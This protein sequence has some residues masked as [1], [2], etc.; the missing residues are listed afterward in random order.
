MALG[1]R[2][3]AVAGAVALAVFGGA[4]SSA[5]QSGRS[6]SSSTRS[7]MTVAEK[8]RV[9]P[10]PPGF[11][12]VVTEVDG[13]V[14]A[15]A[16]GRTFYRWPRNGQRNGEAG[17]RK[18]ESA[19][20]RERSTVN[21]GLMSPYPGGF[22]LPDVE[23]RP[24]CAEAWPPVLAAADAKP[25][26]KWTIT[27]NKDG[28]PQWAY[29]GWPLY[30]SAYDHGPGDVTGVV[31]W[32][33][34]RS[35]SYRETVSPPSDAP[36][37]LLVAT[38]SR[39]RMIVT[40]NSLAVYASDRDGDKKSNCDAECQ[41]VW[42]PLLAPQVL[43]S[44]GDW[45][46][47]ERS[48]GVRQWAFRGRPLYVNLL[49]RYNRSQEGSDYPGWHNVYTQAAPAWPSEF[50]V[51]ETSS[52]EVLAD[53]HGKTIY[54]Y[55]CGDD[56]VDQLSCDHPSD[57]QAY[58]F[59]MCGGGDPKRCLE[60][61]PYLLAR[62]DAKS[63]NKTWTVVVIDPVTGHFA[64]EGSPGALRVWAYKQRPVYT[65]SRDRMPGDINADGWG[66]IRGERNGFRA[67]WLRDDFFGA[68]G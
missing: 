52:G 49:D 6:E 65:F 61:F 48:P 62:D 36:P 57:T 30:T 25:I 55:G 64:A 27:K 46:A 12:V 24:T 18:G 67:F 44:Q 33:R 56:S 45:S 54:L 58:R 35:P 37:G 11:Q 28:Q 39:G 53:S 23:T 9:T 8:F 26:E 4:N 29:D 68:A 1:T 2:T 22:T 59:G 7:I 16:N 19:C 47:F 10:L 43:Q 31:K 17:E 5:Q 20:G 50:T 51:Q 38:T 40:Q 34:T 66:E 32:G 13:P 3:A 63:L 21:T 42:K 14:F 41:K 15:D 60:T